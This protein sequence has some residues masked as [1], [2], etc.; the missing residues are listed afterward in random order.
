MDAAERGL[1]YYLGWFA[2]PIFSKNGDY[3]PVMKNTIAYRSALEGFNVSRLP[4]FREDEVNFI[5]G[6]SDFF[7]LT[8]DETL[9]A[10]EGAIIPISTPSFK[11]DM[12]ISQFYDNTWP[13]TPIGSYSIA[14]WGMYNIL[15]YI[16]NRYNSPEIYITG[17]G[18]PDS[19]TLKDT[20]R[21][22]YFQQY[23]SSVLDAI[24]NGVLV[25]SY[26]FWSLLDGFEWEHGYNLKYGVVH[27]D[28]D[29]T[30]RTRTLKL[31]AK[32]VKYLTKERHIEYGPN[33]GGIV[34][35]P[36]KLDGLEDDEDSDAEVK[37]TT[38][39]IKKKIDVVND[40]I[41]S[42]E[43]IFPDIPEIEI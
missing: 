21:I 26:T 10:S 3:P 15:M 7:G 11:H 36:E 9:L 12:N 2:N 24:S 17:S 19:G 41:T 37:V 43:N 31:S 33:V 14:P 40:N 13:R 29:N 5:K 35:I 42:I 4:T 6:T 25:T 39:T 28:F 38:E 30:S 1:Q 18:Y 20:G 32:F 8:H 27:V 22:T 16:H 34:I 23:L